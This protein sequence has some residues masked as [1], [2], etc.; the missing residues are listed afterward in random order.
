MSVPGH[1]SVWRTTNAKQNLQVLVLKHGQKRV[2]VKR[3]R[4]YD[5]VLD[6]VCKHF[7]SIPR[8]MITLQTNQL[9]VCDG[10]YVD[11]TAEIWN[12][13]VDSLNVVEVTRA[14]TTLPVPLPV[15]KLDAWAVSFP[16]NQLAPS[17][18]NKLDS[19]KKDDKVTIKVV[20]PS[21][22]IQTAKISRAMLVDE[23]VLMLVR[24]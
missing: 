16:A 19:S 18:V 5:L 20:F 10:Y 14:E 24:Y 6:S 1:G 7:P 2:M 8:D 23:L 9:D 3:Q 4:S 15:D 12:D 22:E 17:Q 11:I 21:G 13:I